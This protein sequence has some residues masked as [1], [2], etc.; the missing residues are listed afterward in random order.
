MIRY[1]AILFLSL[2]LLPVVPGLYAQDTGWI[3]GKISERGNKAI[4]LANVSIAGTQTGTVTSED[5]TYRLEVP[6][7]QEI[8][9]VISCIGYQSLTREILLSDNEEL[10]LD[11]QLEVAIQNLDEV[12]IREE[13]DRSSTLNRINIKTLHLIPGSGGSVEALL[14]TLPG[15]ASGNELSSQYSVRG[16]NFD[17]NLV[18]VNDIEIYRPFLIRSG[19]QE[20]MSFVNSQMVSS[21][22]FSAGGF[23]ASYGDKMS[24]VLDITYRRPVEFAGSVDMSL[25]GASVHL[26]DAGRNG[27]LTHNSGFRYKTSQYLLSSLETKGEYLPNFYDYQTYITY[28]ISDK[29]EFSFLGNAA[30][31]SYK[32]IPENRSTDFGTY[33]NPLN[34]VIYY[35]GQ[36]Q[37]RFNTYLGAFTIHYRPTDD[38]SL[39]FINSGFSSIEKE[40]FDIQGQYLINELDNRLDSETFG[41]S[42]LNIGIGTFLNHARNKLNALVYSASHIGTWFSDNAQLKWGTKYQYEYINDRLGE[43]E[44]IDSA[45]YSIPYSDQQI[46]LA[47][48]TRSDNLIRSNRMTAFL[49]ASYNLTDRPIRYYFNGGIRANYWDY[50]GQLLISPRLTISM[51]PSWDRD[52]ILRFSTG[53]YHQPPFYKELRYLDGSINPLARAQKSIHFVVGGDY[54][55]MAW[56]RPFVLTSEIYYKHLYDLIPY[57]V[58]NVRIQYAAENIAGGYATGIEFKI[59]GEFVKDAESWAS[60]SI[61]RTAEDI[62]GDFHLDESGNRIEPGFYPRPTDQIL[63]FGLFFQDYFPNNPEYKVNLNFLYGSKLPFSPPHQDRYDLVF[64]MPSYKRVDIGFSKVL[65]KVDSQLSEGN[66]FR[67]FRSIWLSGEIFNLLGVNNTISYLWV[68]TVSN[69]DNVPGQF[70]VPNYLTSR[71]FNLRL[72]ARF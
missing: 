53:A 2:L 65:K 14:K 18:Y 12:S 44:L 30:S 3:S 45:G 66:P 40:N 25:L 56:G 49:Q 16:G 58:D 23:E 46:Q 68:K 35:D 26:E 42:I 34:L 31:N 37:D 11:I 7:N 63:N 64:R 22:K 59:N 36:E 6:A 1:P 72:T 47:S 61:M 57:K 62:E 28:Q 71:R 70:A 13:A 32:F 33:Q 50:N 69:Q 67:H 17:E 55:F 38:L 54:N 8:S 52:I 19:Q 60:L 4:F 24:S 10:N 41:D 21:V 48:I 5:G 39:K 9:L 29:I 20:G 27:R 43:W 15:V 51:K